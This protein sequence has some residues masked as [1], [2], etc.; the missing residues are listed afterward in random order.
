M[1]DVKV[2]SG[3]KVSHQ[4]V[5]HAAQQVIVKWKENTG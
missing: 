3:Y 5:L 1:E 4:S 2:T